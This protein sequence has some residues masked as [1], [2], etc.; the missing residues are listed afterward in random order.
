MIE[1]IALIPK[2]LGVRP[3]AL[4]LDVSSLVQGTVMVTGAGGSIGAEVSMQVASLN[5]PSLILVER[6]EFALYQIEMR[7]RESGYKGKLIPI[8]GSITDG[9]LMARVMKWYA[10]ETILHTAAYKHVPLVERNPLVGVENNFL[11]TNTLAT[12]AVNCNVKTFVMVSTDKAVKPTNTMGASK[13]L[14]EWACL[15]KNGGQ[16]SFTVVRFGNVMWSSG[17]VLPL[18][19]AQ[20]ESTKIM[21]VTHEEVS[22][23]FMS[24][25]E[26]VSLVLQ[27][28]VLGEGIFVLDM[29]SPV[30]IK[31]IAIRLAE[32]M[33]VVG[34]QIKYIGLRPGEKLY[35]ELTLGEK[36]GKTQHSRIMSADERVHADIDGVVGKVQ[37][38]IRNRDTGGLR[39]LLQEEVPGY[40][41]MC[42]IVDALWLQEHV[43][44]GLELL[45]DCYRTPVPGDKYE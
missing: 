33:G 11:G 16:T 12:C 14:A 35:E 24:V 23:F 1:E 27:A 18:F 10:V 45:D 21:T 17:S 6:S 9:C 20:L 39:I 40:I 30:L 26:A 4:E 34:H 43:Y 41:P 37:G 42:G 15:A 19:K 7:V 36:L 3:V 44:H 38:M 8:L 13:R 28:S 2:L 22:R 5:P 31:D 29:G 25:Q 32:E